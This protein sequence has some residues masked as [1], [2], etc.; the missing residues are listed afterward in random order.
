MADAQIE[1]ASLMSMSAIQ[2]TKCLLEPK[3]WRTNSAPSSHC[4]RA[5]RTWTANTRQPSGTLC[6]VTIRIANVNQNRNINR[7][8]TTN[9]NPKRSNGYKRPATY[10]RRPDRT[11]NGKSQWIQNQK[12]EQLVHRWQWYRSVT[13]PIRLIAS[14][15]QLHCSADPRGTRQVLQHPC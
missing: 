14:F 12:Y 11:N 9:P 8:K 3:L 15:R 10:G 1:L 13:Q 4:L 7:N 5:E 6:R 2:L